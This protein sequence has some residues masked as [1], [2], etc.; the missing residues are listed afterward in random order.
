MPSLKNTLHERFARLISQGMTQADAF[1]ACN[2]DTQSAKTGGCKWYA[3]M[4]VRQR[5]AELREIVD[6]QFAMLIGEKRDLL[7]RMARGEIPTKVTRRP[8]G[9]LEATFDRLAALEMDAQIAGEFAPE[10]VQLEVG[11]TLKLDFG[12]IQRDKALPPTLEA[13]LVDLSTYESAQI[14]RKGPQL[15]DLKGVIDE[16]VEQQTATGDAVQESDTE[17]WN[18]KE[19]GW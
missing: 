8:G 19:Q 11:P 9:K 10:Q 2:P 1:K 4:D 18:S 13:E 6:Q 12:T 17:G 16:P 7:R 3:R 14:D 5:V 15:A